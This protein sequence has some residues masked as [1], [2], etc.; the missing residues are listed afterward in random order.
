MRL[1]KQSSVTVIIIFMFTFYL[2]CTATRTDTGVPLDQTV[3]ALDE[4]KANTLL[5][6]LLPRYY[7]GK[8]NHINEMPGISFF[9]EKCRKGEPIL[10]LN[11]EFGKGEV[12][13]S[14]ERQT[15]GIQMEGYVFLNT[16]GAWSFQAL[17]N[18][19]IRIKLGDTLVVEDPSMHADRLSEPMVFNAPESGWYPILVRY[20]QKKGTATLKLY[21]KGP[22]ASGFSII[23]KTAFG[24]FYVQGS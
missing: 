6:G 23:P 15:I 24:H 4:S 22:G 20:F 10:Y 12:F 7:N 11:H 2:G 9:R 5:K 1:C 18:D 21:Y 13:E 8:W 17:A 3:S 14:G 16:K 19:G